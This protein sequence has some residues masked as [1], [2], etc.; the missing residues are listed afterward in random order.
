VIVVVPAPS[1]LV[2]FISTHPLLTAVLLVVFVVVVPAV[3]SR[4]PHR[5][6]AA[7]AVLGQMLL[8]LVLLAR[9]LAPRTGHA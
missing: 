6:C 3:W 8:A 4:H 7:A 2:L 5:R 9:A 1:E